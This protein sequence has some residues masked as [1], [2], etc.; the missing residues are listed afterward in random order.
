MKKQKLFWG[1]ILVAPTVLYVLLMNVW[2]IIQTIYFSFNRIKGLGSPSWIGFANYFTAF[3]DPD[4]HRALGNTFIYTI[5]TVP[6]GTVLS[7]LVA[8]FLNTKIRFKSFFR[9]LYFIPVVTAPA[10]IGIVWRWLYNAD[11]GLINYLLSII[12]ISGPNWIADD[13]YVLI[14]IM[15]VGIWSGIGYNMIILLGGLQDIPTTYYEA[16]EMDGAG[17][18]RKFFSVTLPLLSPTMFF[19]ITTS[20]IGSLQVFD[21]IF[22]MVDKG[23]PALKSAQSV[24]YLFYRET[25]VANNKGYGAAIAVILLGIILICTMVQMKLQKKWVHYQ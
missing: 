16:A 4:L 8:V 11:F 1:I 10:A 15:I 12:G 6:V 5:I 2:P 22:M 24:V 14:A 23:N 17:P 20:F 21:L 13:R 25:F 3:R 9:V 18:I 7:L 19:V